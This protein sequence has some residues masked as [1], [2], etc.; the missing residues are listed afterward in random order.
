VGLLDRFFV[1]KPPALVGLDISSSGVKLVEL[2]RL[3]TGE[4]LIERMASEPFE[5]GWVVDGQVEKFE[6]VCEAVKRALVRSATKTKSVAL[7]MPASAVITKRILLP[8]GLRE[9]ELEQQVQAEAHQYIPFPLD[10]VALDFCVIGPSVSAPGDLDVLLAA[11]RRDKVQDRQSL[12]EAV[13]LTPVILD[14]ESYAARLAMSR[15]VAALPDEGKGM[16]VA[17][18]EIGAESTSLKVLLDDDLLYDRD[19]PFGGGQLT[20]LISQQYG[21]SFEEAEQKKLN[22]ELPEDYEES[23]L[24]PF[25]GSLAQEIDRALQYFFT[26]TPHHKVDYVMLAGGSACLPGIDD[27]VREITEFPCRVINPFEGMAIGSNI[28]ETKLAKEAPAYLTAC[29]LAMRRFFQ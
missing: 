17:L 1:R 15:L 9:D 25:V 29:G 7:A 24:V 21:L 23:L 11:S 20:Q 19:Q 2:G 3:P 27:K 6:E 5:K 26:S 16:L 14:V 8:D 10:E 4:L 22:N 13:G 18:F 12:A 28:R